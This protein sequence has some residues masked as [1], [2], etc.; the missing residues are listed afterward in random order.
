[1]HTHISAQ[2][3]AYTPT[4][5]YVRNHE[6]ILIPSIPVYQLGSFSSFPLP[7]LHVPSSTVRTLASSVNTFN[8][9]FNPVLH[10]KHCQNCF[11][12]TSVVKTKY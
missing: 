6:P 2:K 5:I 7:S 3:Q 9:L 12:D 10:V 8:H 4:C 1:M 11:A